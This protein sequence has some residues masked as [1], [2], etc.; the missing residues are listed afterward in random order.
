MSIVLGCAGCQDSFPPPVFDCLQYENTEREGVVPSRRH[1]GD[2]D[3]TLDALSCTVH[4]KAS[5]PPVFQYA[6][7]GRG[8]PGRSG[9][10]L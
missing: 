3:E 1:M 9:N 6:K 4:P 10:A 2:D 7:Y 8:T 5:H